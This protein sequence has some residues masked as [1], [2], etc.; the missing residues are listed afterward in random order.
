LEKIR[1]CAL[2]SLSGESLDGRTDEIFKISKNAVVALIFFFLRDDNNAYGQKQERKKESMSR[3]YCD[4]IQRRMMASFGVVASSYS[5]SSCRCFGSGGRRMATATRKI[6]SS[7]D[8]RV[9]P[10]LLLHRHSFVLCGGGSSQI[11]AVVVVGGGGG[12]VQA[13]SFSHF[14]QHAGGGGGG[15]AHHSPFSST[16]TRRT[17]TTTTTMATTT[18]N[19]ISFNKNIHQNTFFSAAKQESYF[20]MMTQRCFETEAAYHDVADATLETI[21]DAIDEALGG[22]S[23]NGNENGTASVIEYECNLAS[24]VLTLT[25]PP[26]G[27]WVLNKQTPNRQIWWSSP[28]SGPKRFEYDDKEIW[29]STKDGLSLGPLLQQEIAHVTG[30]TMDLQL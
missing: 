11:S 24:G 16:A 20:I 12:G 28:L 5:F 26:H 25:L 27:T 6:S 3:Q 23:V 21:Q 14:S 8:L 17:M 10:P 18:T 9:L 1:I 22:G 29:F 2:G 19:N 15:G 13:P 7:V 4:F 30:K